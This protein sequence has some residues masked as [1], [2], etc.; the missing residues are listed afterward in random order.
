MRTDRSLLKLI[1][2]SI[3]T[4]GIYWLWF[5]SQ[6]AKDMNIACEGDSKTTRGIFFRILLSII[7]LGIYEFVWMYGVGSRIHNNCYQKIFLAKQQAEMCY[8]GIFLVP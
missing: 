3:I 8:Y 5:W 7:T 1:L 6:F 2:L 4:L